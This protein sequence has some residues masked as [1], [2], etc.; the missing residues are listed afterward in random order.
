MP[1]RCTSPNVRSRK[2]TR[3]TTRRVGCSA[4][5]PQ[6]LLCSLLRLVGD[7][8]SPHTLLPAAHVAAETGSLST[9]F[10]GLVP[11]AAYRRNL[12][13]QDNRQTSEFNLKSTRVTFNGRLKNALKARHVLR[14]RRIRQWRQF[15]SAVASFSANACERLMSES[16][17]SSML[18]GEFQ[19][20]C[21]E[22]NA[23]TS[24]P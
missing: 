15:F 5:P 16:C 6:I 9:R 3:P 14:Q 8:S 18:I 20:G 7:A 13:G 17:R 2:K 4:K 1:A 10:R 19:R 22:D 21:L 24:T 23:F 12:V 11:E